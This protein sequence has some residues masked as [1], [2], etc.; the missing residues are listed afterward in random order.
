MSNVRSHA[1]A[2]FSGSGPGMQTADGCSVELYRQLPYHGELEPV[3]LSFEPGAKV[4]ELGC[5][6]GR[7]TRKMLDWGAVVTAVDNSAEMLAAVPSEAH[8]VLGDIESLQLSEEFALVVLASNLVNHPTAAVRQA[9]LRV[10]R[11]HL[12]AGGKVLVERQ[13]PEWL[14]TAQPGKQ[15]SVGP[16]SLFMESVQREN[17]RVRIAL[18]YELGSQAWRQSFEAVVLQE[19]EVEAMLAEAGFAGHTWFGSRRRWVQSVAV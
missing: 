11:R 9:F 13:D 14:S 15:G 19:Y 3:R 16:V 1:E 18:R 7:H 5:G 6:T 8:K 12:A 2:P 4:L 10:A 17:Q